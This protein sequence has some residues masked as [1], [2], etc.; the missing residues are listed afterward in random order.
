M[1]NP[2]FG[3]SESFSELPSIEAGI[4]Q[5][6]SWASD[7]ARRAVLNQQVPVIV[8]NDGERKVCGSALVEINKHGGRPMYA[9]SLVVDAE[10]AG[11]LNSFDIHFN[12]KLSDSRVV[13]E[14]VLEKR[15]N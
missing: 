11:M 13:T 7:V 1:T 2:W 3:K 8:D 12:V 4:V 15:K 14:V 6:G 9:V 5:T 10:S